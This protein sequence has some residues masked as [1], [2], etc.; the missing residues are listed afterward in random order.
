MDNKWL[1]WFEK[2]CADKIPMTEKEAYR[3]GYER[4]SRPQAI[5]IFNKTLCDSVEHKCSLCGHVTITHIDDGPANY[6][7]FCGA[8]MAKGE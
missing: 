2:D 4:G 7:P 8:E 5:W 1:K 6:C 3:L